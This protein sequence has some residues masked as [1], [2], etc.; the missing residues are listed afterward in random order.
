[1]QFLWF[2]GP[3]SESNCARHN[4]FFYTAT[5]RK[6]GGFWFLS[7]SILAHLAMTTTIILLLLRIN[8]STGAVF[9]CLVIASTCCGASPHVGRGWLV[10]GLSMMS[11]NRQVT[12]NDRHSCQ[13]LWACKKVVCDENIQWSIT[14]NTESCILSPFTSLNWT[15]TFI[16]YSYYFL[17]KN[18]HNRDQ[19]VMQFFLASA[20]PVLSIRGK[21]ALQRVF[22]V[23]MNLENSYVPSSEKIFCTRDARKQGKK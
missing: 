2:S 4:M 17:A 9:P 19:G 6:R 20:A 8:I 22:W 10:F 5:G 15:L 14:I 18:P 12:V 13:P 7:G 16:S 21:S 3:N 23:I 1:M 11:K